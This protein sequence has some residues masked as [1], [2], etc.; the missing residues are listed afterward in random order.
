M[1]KT[2]AFGVSHQLV[3]AMPIEY[4][5][6]SAS[7][8]F[9]FRGAAMELFGGVATLVFATSLSAKAFN[10]LRYITRISLMSS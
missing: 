4:F 5:Q 1:I 6:E 9:S 8:E 7:V 3:Y 10:C 2:N